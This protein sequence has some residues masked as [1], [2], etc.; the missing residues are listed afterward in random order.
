MAFLRA[1]RP[2][3]KQEAA[4]CHRL[5]HSTM[6]GNDLANLRDHFLVYFEQAL[7]Q[8]QEG[9]VEFFTL[10]REMVFCSIW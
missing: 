3:F 6:V 10:V 4:A 2:V 9:E 7:E 1:E 8:C 5:L